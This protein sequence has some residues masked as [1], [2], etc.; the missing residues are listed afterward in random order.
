MS[1]IEYEIIDIRVDGDNA[2]VIVSRLDKDDSF[3]VRM[4]TVE[5]DAMDNTSL[6][7]L[8]QT[9]I[10]ARILELAEV[11][12]KKSV[13]DLKEQDYVSYKGRKIKESI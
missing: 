7:A 9:E 2:V 13:D 4:T 11:E 3:G 8:L 6:D 1:A 5:L 12:T 10:D